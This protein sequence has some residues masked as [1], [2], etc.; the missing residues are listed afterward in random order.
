[1][2][3]IVHQCFLRMLSHKIIIRNATLQTT[4]KFFLQRPLSL[5]YIEIKSEEQL[6]EDDKGP[7][8]LK[9]EV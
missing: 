3:L 1:M 8:T 7:I 5:I 6:D 9:S 2:L 4:N